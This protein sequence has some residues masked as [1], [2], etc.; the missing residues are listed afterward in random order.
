MRLETGDFG[1]ADGNRE[2]PN[3]HQVP[4]RLTETVF[5]DLFGDDFMGEVDAEAAER[6]AA[7]APRS[8]R[9][10][11]GDINDVAEKGEKMKERDEMRNVHAQDILNDLRAAKDPEQAYVIYRYASQV[12]AIT[13]NELQ[14]ERNQDLLEKVKEGRWRL[15]NAPEATPEHDLVVEQVL[16]DLRG[17]QDPLAAYELFERARDLGD[18]SYRD[19]RDKEKNLLVRVQLGLAEK[20]RRDHETRKSAASEEEEP[21]GQARA[22]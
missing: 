17:T 22:A 11:E 2:R 20:L 19:L 7:G 6:D 3:L 10:V 8:W 18:I 15:A 16:G 5:G 14:G 1:G 12:G 21:Q 4:Y 13:H 9:E